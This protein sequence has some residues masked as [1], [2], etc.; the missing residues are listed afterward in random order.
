[1]AAYFYVYRLA[2]QK[3]IALA[4]ANKELQLKM[5]KWHLNP[6]FYFKTIQHLQLLASAKPVNATGPILQL[7]KI[8]EYV[9]YEAKEKWVAVQKELQFINNYTDLLNQQ[10]SNS[11]FETEVHG[12]YGDL[13][14]SPLLLA[15]FIDKIAAGNLNTQ[16]VLFRMQLFFSGNEMTVMINKHF[17]N[18]TPQLLPGDTALQQQ[19]NESYPGKFFFDQTESGSQFKLIIPLHEEH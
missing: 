4:V 12:T 2:Q 11:I 15:A 3:R 7:A 6:S 19:L 14:I 8:M 5:L 9:I 10:N 17:G 13:K 16:K 1:M 18:N